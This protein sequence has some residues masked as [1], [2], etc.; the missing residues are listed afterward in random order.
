MFFAIVDVQHS[1]A[2]DVASYLNIVPGN[3]SIEVG[4]I[5]YSPLLQ[6]TPAAT[7]YE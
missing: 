1:K 7:D 6:R 4:H 3:G 2:V 5:Y